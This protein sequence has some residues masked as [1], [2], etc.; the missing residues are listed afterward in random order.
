MSSQKPKK[1]KLWSGECK[2]ECIT[3]AAKENNWSIKDQ[4]KDEAKSNLYWVDVATINE[5]MRSIQPWQMIN[6]FPGMPNIARKQRMGQNLNKMAKSYPKEYG[7]YPRYV[8]LNI[9]LLF[10]GHLYASFVKPFDGSLI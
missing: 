10:F 8:F 3:D 5:R 1:V 6:H 9:A 2:Y 7:F 4:E